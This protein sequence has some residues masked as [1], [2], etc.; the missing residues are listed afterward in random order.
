MFVR[1]IRTS[2]HF[3]VL[4]IYKKILKL[5]IIVVITVA[6]DVKRRIVTLIPIKVNSSFA[7][8]DIHDAR[9]CSMS[10]EPK[11]LKHPNGIR[12]PSPGCA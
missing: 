4:Q 3:I 7:H 10:V 2:T 12:V 1:F 9:S 8:T 5:F 6:V 11:P